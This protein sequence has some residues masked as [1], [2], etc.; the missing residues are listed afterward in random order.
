[1]SLERI[2]MSNTEAV[3]KQ[4]KPPYQTLI[5]SLEA[6]K[7]QSRAEFLALKNPSEEVSL[8]YMGNMAG[9]QT[10]LGIVKRHSDWISM[11]GEGSFDISQ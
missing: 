10:A 4:S 7:L 8:M 2:T 6:E 1:M 11:N 5:E 9:L 3:V